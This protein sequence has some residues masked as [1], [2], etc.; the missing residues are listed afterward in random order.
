MGADPKS[1]HDVPSASTHCTVVESNSDR[2]DGEGRMNL[3]VVQA[4]M[5]WVLSEEPVAIS[6]PAL[7]VFG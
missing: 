1:D 6:R 5:K 2:I 3:L 7:Y 4:K